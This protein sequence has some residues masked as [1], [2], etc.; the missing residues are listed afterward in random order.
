MSPVKEAQA[1][2]KWVA[3]HP[4]APRS[5][6]RNECGVGGGRENLCCGHVYVR[7]FICMCAQTS[8]KIYVQGGVIYVVASLVIKIVESF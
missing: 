4:S 8:G 2:G 6:K 5:Q 1:D 7:I 3:P